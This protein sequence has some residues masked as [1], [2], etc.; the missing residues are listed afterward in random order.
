MARYSFIYAVILSFVVSA[1]LY[2]TYPYNSESSRFEELQKDTFPEN[3]N[4]Y[5]GRIWKNLYFRVKEDQFL[6]SKE[7]LPGSV[8]M[9]GKTFNNV[10]IR[11]DLYKDEIL[12]PYHSE[13]ILQLNKEMVDSFSIFFQGETYH[14]TRMP[15][16]SPDELKGYVNVIYKGSS[17][18]CVKYLKKIDFK[19]VDGQFDQFYQVSRIYLVKGNKSYMITGNSDLMKV[20]A[21]D[22]VLIKNFIKKNKLTFSK[23]TPESFVPV[24]RYFDTI[25]Q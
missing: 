10:S 12:T 2:E 22:K 4:F 8:T 6:F 19:A 5:N 1:D 9:N 18:L 3:N 11:Y 17:V 20:F 24:I 13:G 15:E 21:E 16:D 7:F 23:D 14:F 25:K